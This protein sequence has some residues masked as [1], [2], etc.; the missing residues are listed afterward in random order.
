MTAQATTTTKKK[1][2]KKLLHFRCTYVT[3]ENIKLEK[4]LIYSI[5]LDRFLGVCAVPNSQTLEPWLFLSPVTKMIPT[6]LVWITYKTE[7]YFWNCWGSLEASQ[8]L[9]KEAALWSCGW[10]K[11]LSDENKVPRTL[12]GATDVAGSTKYK[13]GKTKLC[14]TSRSVFFIQCI[15]S[16]KQRQLV[17]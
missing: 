14:C 1:L 7:N 4:H 11:W 6:Y 10:R 15:Q 16:W 13:Q 2:K 17:Y 8:N 3:N 5:A 9:R 12:F